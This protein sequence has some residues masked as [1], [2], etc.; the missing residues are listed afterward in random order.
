MY[1]SA[2]LVVDV[3]P[4]PVTVTSTVPEPAGAVAVSDVPEDTDTLVAAADPKLTV[5]PAA[6]PLPVTVTVLPPPAAP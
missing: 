2:L 6:N 1:L 4:E 5:S 3:P